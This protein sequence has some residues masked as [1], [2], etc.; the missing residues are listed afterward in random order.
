MFSGCVSRFFAAHRRGRNIC[1]LIPASGCLNFP[2][3]SP[4]YHCRLDYG[5]A[6][7]VGLHPPLSYAPPAVC[8][9]CGGAAYLPALPV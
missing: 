7:L 6:S 8:S 2:S 3:S 5:S 1:R 9:E 4:N